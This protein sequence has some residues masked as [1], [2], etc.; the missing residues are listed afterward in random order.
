MDNDESDLAQSPVPRANLA[1]I[2]RLTRYAYAESSYP[3]GA[4]ASLAQHVKPATDRHPGMARSR[5]H[6]GRFS[7]KQGQNKPGHTRL[8]ATAGRYATSGIRE[9]RNEK[10]DE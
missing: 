1:S 4:S 10:N 9:K 8:G 5:K 6:P 3:S 2:L 7:T